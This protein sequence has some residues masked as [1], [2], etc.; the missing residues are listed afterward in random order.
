M[1]ESGQPKKFYTSIRNWW[2]TD[3]LLSWQICGKQILLFFN[4]YV[5]SCYIG[6]SSQSSI[7]CWRWFILLSLHQKGFRL[8][9]AGYHSPHDQS[10]RLPCVLYPVQLFVSYIYTFNFLD[11]GSLLQWNT[12]FWRKDSQNVSLSVWR[13]GSRN[14]DGIRN[15]KFY[16]SKDCLSNIYYTRRQFDKY[17]YR[18]C[19]VAIICIHFTKTYLNLQEKVQS[20]LR[21]PF[22][23]MRN[24]CIFSTYESAHIILECI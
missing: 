3:K 12:Y 2:I 7:R 19:S 11:S 22:F 23:P 17:Y 21:T 15:G 10:S 20:Q 16:W 24:P 5:V 1:Q 8:A 6:P 18:H 13:H 14:G 4:L 9:F